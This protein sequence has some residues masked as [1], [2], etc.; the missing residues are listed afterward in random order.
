MSKVSDLLEK[1]HAYDY[2]TLSLYE[3]GDALYAKSEIIIDLLK[4]VKSSSKFTMLIDITAVEYENS[5]E[6]VYHVMPVDANV[7]RIKVIL[8]KE[9]PS[10]PSVMSIWKN[11][12][13][14][15]REV[16]D[17]MGIVFEGHDNLKRI[18]CPDDF[19]HHPLRKDF[20]LDAID[21][22]N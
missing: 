12:N 8:S 11:A 18:L 16:F 4:R 9:K 7:I 14:L 6:V 19:Q 5:F 20:K 3:D 17:L 10:I 15:E 1:I 22:F 13:V 2:G 21:R